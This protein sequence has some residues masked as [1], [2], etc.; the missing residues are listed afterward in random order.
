MMW[1]DVLAVVL[2]AAAFTGAVGVIAKAPPV[3]WVWR[4]N[5]S[6]PLT[7]WHRRTTH[8]V[9]DARLAPVKKDIADI[10]AQVHPNGGNS[11]RDAVDKVVDQTATDPRRD[12]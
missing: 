9:V 3:R 2:G 11:L 8:E 7:D 12:P 1:G 10:R 5:V 4:H 6:E